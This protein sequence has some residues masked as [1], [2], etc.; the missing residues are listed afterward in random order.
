MSKQLRFLAFAAEHYRMRH[1][2]S[3]AELAALFSRYGI[4]QLV[5]DNYYLYHIE[6][7]EHMVADIDH[8]IETGTTLNQMPG[9]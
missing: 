4:Y 3:G 6:S 8:F 7:P 1:G 9:V 2:L 5:L